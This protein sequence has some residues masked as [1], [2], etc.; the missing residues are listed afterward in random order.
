MVNNKKSHLFPKKAQRDTN[1][2]LLIFFILFVLINILDI[3]GF[4]RIANGLMFLPLIAF[5][6]AFFNSISFIKQMF[7]KIKNR[8]K[9]KQEI[10]TDDL[11]DEAGQ[12]QTYPTK[13]LPNTTCSRIS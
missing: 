10:F 13:V 8:V 3:I 4:K 9:N 2:A 5:F 11:M 7:N 12:N 1:R 6:I